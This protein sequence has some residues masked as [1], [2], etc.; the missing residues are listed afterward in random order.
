MFWTAWEKLKGMPKEDAQRSFIALTEKIYKENGKEE[1]LVDAN[2]PGPKYYDDCK[3][4]SWVEVLVKSH[5]SY[6]INNNK[7]VPDWKKMQAEQDK[8]LI[9][10]L[11]AR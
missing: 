4:F 10:D 1:Y 9:A 11:K 8:K 3:K 6:Y 7:K 2:W 5:K